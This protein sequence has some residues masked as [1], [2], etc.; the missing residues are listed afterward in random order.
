VQG[1]VSG[2]FFFFLLPFPSSSLR[3]LFPTLGRQ[4]FRDFLNQRFCLDHCA[5]GTFLT[6]SPLL[7]IFLKIGFQSVLMAM[8]SMI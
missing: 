6:F 5:I 7:S 1:V 3:H 8:S 2:S 4:S